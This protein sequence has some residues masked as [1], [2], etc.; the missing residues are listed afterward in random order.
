[1]DKPKTL[2]DSQKAAYNRGAYIEIIGDEVVYDTSDEEY[3]PIYFPLEQLE[4]KIKEHKEK[5]K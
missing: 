1:M 3:G 2:I 5:M 4:Q